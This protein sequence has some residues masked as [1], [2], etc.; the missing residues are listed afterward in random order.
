VNYRGTTAAAIAAMRAAGFE[1]AVANG[2]SAALHKS[3][4]MES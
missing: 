3:M 4:S 2:L 1:A